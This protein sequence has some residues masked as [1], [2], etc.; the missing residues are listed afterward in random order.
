MSWALRPVETADEALLLQVYASTRAEELALTPWD[1]ATRDAFVQM[2]AQAQARHYQAHWPGAEHKIIT[3]TLGSTRHDV[4]R[5]WFDW[6]LGTVH[7]LDLT[8]LPAWRGQ[9]IGTQVLQHLMEDARAR[10]LALTIYVEAGNPARHLYERLGLRPVGPP[11]GV[12][13]FMRWKA[14]PTHLMET[15][16]EQT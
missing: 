14:T 1:A 16:D 9:G 12:H 5:L 3:L 10:G 8:L 13:Q 7:V 11:S 2:Q 4:G 6:R 15:C